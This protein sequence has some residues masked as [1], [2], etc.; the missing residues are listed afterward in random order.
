M[1]AL[2][3]AIQDNTRKRLCRTPDGE[4][5]LQLGKIVRYYMQTLI[6]INAN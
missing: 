3:E 4:E 6:L 5:T 2:N 1:K